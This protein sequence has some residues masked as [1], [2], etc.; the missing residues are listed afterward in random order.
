VAIPFNLLLITPFQ[1]VVIIKF[2]PLD[3]CG[4]LL[5]PPS[6]ATTTFVQHVIP[7]YRPFRN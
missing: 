2:K 3:P 4:D 7:Y 5:E 6:G 1:S